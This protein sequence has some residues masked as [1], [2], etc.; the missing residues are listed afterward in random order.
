MNISIDILNPDSIESAIRA[1]DRVKAKCYTE[2]EGLVADVAAYG[3]EAARRELDVQVYSSPSIWRT[4]ELKNGIRHTVDGMS[5]DITSTADYSIFVEFGTGIV[6]AEGPI[7]PDA[8][9]W[10]APSSFA[11]S[12]FFPGDDGRAVYTEGQEAKSYMYNAFTQ[13]R[14]YAERRLMEIQL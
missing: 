1:L 14:D 13:L 8:P 11:E 3:E 7:A 12:W 4:G 5:A 2:M 10:W 9:S 6:G